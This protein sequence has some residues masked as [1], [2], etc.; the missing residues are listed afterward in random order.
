VQ[1]SR[2]NA[3]AARTWSFGAGIVWEELCLPQM[4]GCF[5]T[6]RWIA[7]KVEV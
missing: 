5:F 2:N 7:L 6:A 3:R 1:T 4:L